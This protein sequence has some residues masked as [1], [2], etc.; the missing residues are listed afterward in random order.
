MKRK[1]LLIDDE[2]LVI[3]SVNRL[4]TREG[5]EVANCKSGEE[6]LE[7][8]KTE[9]FDLVV[10]D[11]RMPHLTGIETIKKI[12]EFQV[13]TG[14]KVMPEILITGYADD[15]ANKEAEALCVADYIYKPFDL[16]D[17]LTCIKKHMGE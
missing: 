5:Y 16:R 2:E 13:K 6:A 10:C 1:I 3:K 14:R 7:K 8:I 17:F 12:R 15:V 11:I 4:L 9:L